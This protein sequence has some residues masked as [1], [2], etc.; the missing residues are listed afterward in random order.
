MGGSSGCGCTE[1]VTATDSKD[2]QVVSAGSSV[3]IGG[4]APTGNLVALFGTA[5]KLEFTFNPGDT[6]S[7]TAGNTGTAL[8]STPSANAFLEI[9]DASSPT[10]SGAQIYFEGNVQAG[11]NIFA[12]ATV[13]PLTGALTSGAASHFATAAGSDLYGFVFTSQQAF[14]SGAAPVQTLAYGTAGQ[15]H[16]GDTVGSLQLS[17]YVGASGGH[18][19]A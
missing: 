18:L 7:V 12:D 5:E 13:N 2:V 17:G 15:M 10:A 4:T 9:S 16:L 11:E 3:T 1:T 6:I 14:E 8:G 19:V